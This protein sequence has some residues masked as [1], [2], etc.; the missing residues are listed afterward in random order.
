MQNMRQR[1]G[2]EPGKQELNKSRKVGPRESVK[3][4]E[5]DQVDAEAD[6]ADPR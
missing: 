1:K 4:V 2:R 6:A 3:D 5:M